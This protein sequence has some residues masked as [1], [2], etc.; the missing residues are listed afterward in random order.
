VPSLAVV[1]IAWWAQRISVMA[2]RV[3]GHV[4][5][6]EL[7]PDASL[8]QSRQV[9]HHRRL[10]GRHFKMR[11]IGCK[12]DRIHRA[13]IARTYEPGQVILGHHGPG[14]GEVDHQIECWQK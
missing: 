5:R 13:L 8:A 14:G 9:R 7:P 10:I 11:G 4:D 1:A 2:R 3:R 6:P 12:I